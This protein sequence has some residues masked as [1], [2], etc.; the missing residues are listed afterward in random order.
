VSYEPDDYDDYDEDGEV[1]PTAGM[2]PDVADGFLRNP[3]RRHPAARSRPKPP[4]LP[5][6]LGPKKSWPE[7]QS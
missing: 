6:T 4:P 3:D 5:T 7:E 1:D 2:P